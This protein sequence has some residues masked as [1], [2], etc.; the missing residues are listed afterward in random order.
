MMRLQQ[1]LKLTV[2]SVLE[3]YNNK[4]FSHRNKVK[5]VNALHVYQVIT[6]VSSLLTILCYLTCI[7]VQK[8]LASHNQLPFKHFEKTQ[9]HGLY[10]LFGIFLKRHVLCRVSPKMK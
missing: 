4:V 10:S 3:L 2:E 7:Y 1:L 9:G 5:L 8:F 6:D